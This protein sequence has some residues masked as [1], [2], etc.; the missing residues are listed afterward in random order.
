MKKVF[1]I[2]KR[3]YT[4]RVR[5]RAFLISTIVTPLLLLGMALLPSFVATHGG[6]IRRVTILDETHDPDL[7]QLIIKK[8]QADNQSSEGDDTNDTPA[9]RTAL[10]VD[11]RSVSAGED[12]ADLRRQYNAEIE[13]DADRAYI[14]LP[15]GLMDGEEPD[16]YARNAGD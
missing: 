6:G 9:S 14:V 5:S 16:Y 4:V 1:V 11:V 15:P 10:I 2:M 7:S 8:A 12:I 13:K 3:E